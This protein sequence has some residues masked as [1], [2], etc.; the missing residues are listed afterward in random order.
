MTLIL[1][2][3]E[4]W[5]KKASS[6]QSHLSQLG[7]QNKHVTETHRKR[8]KIIRVCVC[9]PLRWWIPTSLAAPSTAS[10]AATKLREPPRHE[11]RWCLPIS[12][13]I[14]LCV[15]CSWMGLG[16]WIWWWIRTEG[17]MNGN[18][19]STK[20]RNYSD[21]CFKVFFFFSFINEDEESVKNVIIL[22]Y[23]KTISNHGIF[24]L[25]N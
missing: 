2:C 18:L 6:K 16:V 17:S 5:S 23:I 14:S 24:C 10:A 13:F 8:F 7:A 25:H 12:L 1:L 22:Y 11:T 15:R 9:F 20:A 19:H 3:D 4:T 21:D